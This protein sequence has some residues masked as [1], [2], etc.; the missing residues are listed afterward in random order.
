[1]ENENC[2]V[3][4][5]GSMENEKYNKYGKWKMKTTKNMKYRK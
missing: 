1:M 2:K 4:K 3:R 5:M